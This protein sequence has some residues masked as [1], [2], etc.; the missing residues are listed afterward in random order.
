[1]SGG[2]PARH[3]YR[4]KAEF[5]HWHTAV[6]GD[7]ARLAAMSGVARRTLYDWRAKW[8]DRDEEQQFPEW[9]QPCRSKEETDPALIEKLVAYLEARAVPY[10]APPVAAPSGRKYATELIGCDVQYPFVHDAAWEV[11]LGIADVLQPEGITLNGDTLDFHYLGHYRKDPRVRADMQADLD[12][13]RDRVFGR[14][15]AAAPKARKRLTMGNHDWDR[16]NNYLMD[17][18][19]EIMNLRVLTSHEGFD[20]LLGLPELGWERFTEGYWLIDKVFRVGHGVRVSN[21]LGGGSA[22]AAR[23]TM[24]DWGCSGVMGHTHRLGAF[25]RVDPI[26]YRVWHEG[27]CLCDQH[28]MRDAHVTS[29]KVSGTIE[30]WHLGCCRVDWNPGGDSFI[31]TD[32]P[33][34]E[35]H[36]RTFAIVNDQEVAA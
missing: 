13:C 22:D 11:F 6:D 32:I 30:D 14:V 28:K 31:I 7:L 18:A 2:Q 24:F 12:E 27:G 10:S 34:L 33:I 16:W 5:V 4:S 15:N 1:M 17:R 35:S 23:K 9:E 19:P 20:A 26:S 36:G 3:F 29:H 21:K 8:I 25:Y